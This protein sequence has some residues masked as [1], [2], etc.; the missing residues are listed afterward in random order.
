MDNVWL[1][2]G[3][4]L[5]VAMGFEFINGFHDTANSIATT[6]STRVLSPRVAIV[7]AATFNFIG[8]YVS[9]TLFKHGVAKTIAAGLINDP[10]SVPQHVI[11]GALCAAILW[12][13]FTW[14][15]GLPSSS[16]HALIGGLLGA[17]IIDFLNVGVV[18]WSG[19]W[20]KVVL[21]LFA[22][23]V[24][25]FV[26]AFLIMN[27]LFELLRKV[28][29]FIAVKVFSKLQIVSSAFMAF[30]HGS[31]DAQKTMGILTLAMISISNSH[32]GQLPAWMM[33]I[34]N[35]QSHEPPLWI[36]IFCGVVMA[37]GT[38]L[39]GW[40]IIKTMGV[41]MI[42]LDPVG[43]FAAETAAAAMIQV[44]SVGGIPLSTTHV[45]SSSIMGVGAAKRLSAVRWSVARN[46]V[47]AWVVTIPVTM[48]LGALIDLVVKGILRVA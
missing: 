33:P 42:K 26:I 31:N 46:M 22:S 19:V 23:P 25:G 17:S 35:I 5:V 30:S 7:M 40:R 2:L 9:T 44:A 47:F 34:A 13:L 27:L 12:G 8:A 18:N 43:G 11:L 36:I 45:I 3:V 41:N 38:S 20:N 28:S 1:I 32:P 21:W 29:K 10:N 37:L 15:M 48:I 14:R 4:I 6:V 24:I 39:G 16:S